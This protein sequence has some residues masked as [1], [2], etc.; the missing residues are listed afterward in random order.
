MAYKASAH[1]VY[2]LKYP[3]V[4]TPKY[5][6]ALLVGEVA[7]AVQDLFAQIAAAYDMEI[8]TR[9]VM[10]TMSICFSLPHH[11]T[12]L[13]GLSK[14]SKASPPGNSLRASRGCAVR[15]G[16]VNCGKTAIS[17]VL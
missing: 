4:W 16:E 10:E 14:S 5:R 13:R 11:G 3:I 2:D 7:Q 15:C 6:K 8:D 12:R 1:A 9:E 17:Y